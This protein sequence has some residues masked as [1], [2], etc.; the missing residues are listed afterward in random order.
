MPG[1]KL[2]DRPAD[3][4]VFR[5]HYRYSGSDVKRLVAEGRE[6]G[7]T[8]FLTTEKDRVRLGALTA[9]FPES[10]PLR[11]VGLRIEIEHEEEAVNW[12]AGRISTFSPDS[13][14]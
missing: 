13:P 10:M 3:A 6:A 1:S 11:S 7:A 2:P 8:A 12:L 9:Q 14:L 4:R 5:D